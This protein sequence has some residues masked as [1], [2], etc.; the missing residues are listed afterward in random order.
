[1]KTTRHTLT[2]DNGT[3]TIS[4]GCQEMT[5][6]VHTGEVLVTLTNRVFA[7]SNVDLTPVGRH[8]FTATVTRDGSTYALTDTRPAQREAAR[9]LTHAREATAAVMGY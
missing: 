4:K 6:T 1:M 5:I 8:P 3:V 9:L 7:A 2:R